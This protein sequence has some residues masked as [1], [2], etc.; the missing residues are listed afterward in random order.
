MQLLPAVHGWSWTEAVLGLLPPPGQLE[1]QGLKQLQRM[2]R[3]TGVKTPPGG[4]CLVPNLIPAIPTYTTVVY[5]ARSSRIKILIG[6]LMLRG[7]TV[8]LRRLYYQ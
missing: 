2:R 4:L 7:I 3:N 5:P 8:K 1:Q 6:Y